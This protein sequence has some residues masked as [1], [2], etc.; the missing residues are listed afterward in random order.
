MN[1]PERD[2][3][4]IMQMVHKGYIVRTRADADTK[5]ARRNDNTRF[6]VACRSGAQI[7]T[8]DYYKKSAHFRSDYSVSF[9]NGKYVR[10]NPI[11]Y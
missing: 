10:R 5:E 7:I 4:K 11:V 9:D 3:S 8:T 1:D 6:K 2:S